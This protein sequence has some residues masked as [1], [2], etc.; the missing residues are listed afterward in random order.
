M[1]NPE[2]AT[3]IER[4]EAIANLIERPP[5]D[6]VELVR[7]V[8]V[9]HASDLRTVLSALS[10]TPETGE[11]VRGEGELR[12][13]MISAIDQWDAE[14]EYGTED[15]AAL[16]DEILRLVEMHPLPTTSSTVEGEDRLFQSV[17]ARA[18]AW[19]D[20]LEIQH[21]VEATTSIFAKWASPDLL[22]RFRQQMM[23]VIQQAFIEGFAEALPSP[24]VQ[25]QDE[26]GGA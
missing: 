4:L 11:P 24:A 21:L 6:D 20:S 26:T 16:A 9:Q 15:H 8:A 13:R 2:L 7:S 17:E 14:T 10:T 18:E 25:R 19:S 5:L 22:S 3:A 23:A 12:L 1:T